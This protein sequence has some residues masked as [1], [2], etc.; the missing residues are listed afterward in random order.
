MTYVYRTDNM[1]E[2]DETVFVT[3]N[4]LQADEVVTFT[5]NVLQA[6]RKVLSRTICCKRTRPSTK[7]RSARA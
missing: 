3:T 4:Q 5:T 6:D 1:L 2:A 7:G